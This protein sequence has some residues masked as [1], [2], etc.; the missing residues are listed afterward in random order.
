MKSLTNPLS[1]RQ[2]IYYPAGCAEEL[3]PHN[4]D[5]CEDQEHGRLRGVAFVHKTYTFVDPTDPTEWQTAIAAGHIIIIPKTNGSYDGGTPKEGPGYGDAVST[6]L[7]SD[8]SA[9]YKDPNYTSNCAFYNGLKRSRNWKFAYLTETKV[10]ITSTACVVLPKNPVADDLNSI[11]EW[12]IEV[13]WSHK[14]FA[15]PFD[16][17]EGIFD[18]CFLTE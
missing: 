14:D 17:P 13:K 6:Y 11:V 4:C 5:P 10:H 1:I 2:L 18:E 3:N 8:F 9:K 15:C 7:G 16:I 12:D